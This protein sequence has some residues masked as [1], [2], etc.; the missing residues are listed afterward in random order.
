M[1][2]MSASLS[3]DSVSASA[4]GRTSRRRPVTGVNGTADCSFG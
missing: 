4:P 3:S 1:A 2:A